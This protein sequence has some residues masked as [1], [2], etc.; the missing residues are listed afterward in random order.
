MSFYNSV[1]LIINTIVIVIFIVV[2][3]CF[4]HEY[5]VNRLN[6]RLTKYA[7]SKDSERHSLFDIIVSFYVKVKRKASKSF[8]LLLNK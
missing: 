7:I 4:Y 3:L 1:K 2:F 8:Y 6:K 5:K